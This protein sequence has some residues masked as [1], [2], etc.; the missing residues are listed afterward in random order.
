MFLLCALFR[1]LLLLEAEAAE[2][3]D[4]GGAGERRVSVPLIMFLLGLEA[5]FDMTEKFDCRAAVTA[6]V[7]NRVRVRVP[8]RTFRAGTSRGVIGKR[9]S[10]SCDRMRH[11]LPPRRSRC[12]EDLTAAG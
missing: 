5:R 8:S 2:L 4:Q 7:R 11:F 10:F 6:D 12:R 1:F 9:N 3:V